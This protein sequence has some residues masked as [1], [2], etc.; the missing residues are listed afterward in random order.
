MGGNGRLSV[1]EIITEVYRLKSEYRRRNDAIDVFRN[2]ANLSREVWIPESM[3]KIAQEVRTPFAHDLIQRIVPVLVPDQPHFRRVP[4]DETDPKEIQ[5]ADALE[6]WLGGLHRAIIQKTARD[7]V[8]M[9]TDSAA[10]DGLG[11]LKCVIDKDA[12]AKMPHVDDSSYEAAENSMNRRDRYKR[13]CPVPFT[14]FDIDPKTYFPV[15]T[16]AGISAVFEIKRSPIM[17]LLNAYG[18]VILSN[19]TPEA[20]PPEYQK[21][22]WESPGRDWM[23]ANI[24]EITLRQTVDVVEFWSREQYVLLINNMPVIN[25]TNPYGGWLPYFD[26]FGRQT[27]LREHEHAA[28]ST[29]FAIQ[30][31]VPLLDSLLTMR[32]N[33]AFSESYPL[34]VKHL[35]AADNAEVE[36][37]NEGL[38]YETGRI[39]TELKDEEYRYLERPRASQDLTL[40]I[41]Q[42]TAL[43]QQTGIAD[44]MKGLSPGANSPGWLVSQLTD[45]A[46]VSFR[47]IRDNLMRALNDLYAFILH[48]VDC[49]LEDDVPIKGIEA[50]RNTGKR[51]ISIGPDEINGYYDI[52]AVIPQGVLSDKVMKGQ[53]F[54]GMWQQGLVSKRYVQTE[55]L[56]IEQPEDMERAIR[57]EKLIAQ[58]EPPLLQRAM[59]ESGYTDLLQQEMGS[60]MSA[61]GEGPA[62]LLPGGM[63]APG[64]G[65]GSTPDM[66]MLGGGG[67]ALPSGI[68]VRSNGAGNATQA[69]INMPVGKN[70]STPTGQGRAPSQ[71]RTYASQLAGRGPSRSGTARPGGARR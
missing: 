56:E 14:V 19:F 1:N 38:L 4:L 55:G 9:G 39:L 8:V 52:E 43:I 37:E 34:L 25:T 40:M 53:F 36:E 33:V 29:L 59:A 45:A 22:L 48:A 46:K 41:E 51:W 54:A 68:N 3:R 2:L 30:Y 70:P 35:M 17:P 66:D 69:H 5:N 10:R 65:M 50:P 44:V 13:V 32:H 47:P 67:G 20:D 57:F 26:F 12:W 18:D 58:L 7:F 21:L 16:N 49:V 71:G 31:L 63:R 27:S 28:V 24:D 6:K 23:G 42:V 15:R 61:S 60:M 64:Q 62:A 11:V